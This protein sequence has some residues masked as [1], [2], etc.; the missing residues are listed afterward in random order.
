[1]DP[2]GKISG[3]TSTDAFSFKIVT[4]VSKWDY[5]T[6]EHPDVGSVL[7]QVIEIIRST[8]EAVAKCMIIGYRTERGFLRKP[9]TPFAPGSEVFH[10]SDEAIKHTLGLVTAGLY[11]GLLEGKEN[12]KTFID[13]RK[14][15]TKHLAILAKSGAGKSYTVGVILEELTAFGVP[16][17]VLDPHGE[18][19]S[20]RHANSHPDDSKYFKNYDIQPQGFGAQVQEYALNTA[21]NTSARQIKLKIPN[22]P[23]KLGEIMPFKLS[24]AQKGLLYNIVNDLVD[25]KGRFDFND[26]I[27]GLEMNESVAKWRLISGLRN[28]EKTN[29]F[30]FSP[31]PMGELV[32]PQQISIINFK[33][34]P[35]E[36]QEIAVSALVSELFEERKL[37]NISPFFLI[38]EEAHNYCP[39]RGFGEA[40]SSKVLRTVASEGR[41]FGLG[42]SIISQ[43]PGRVDKN[44]LSQCTS[45]ISLQVTNPNDLKAISRSFEG[46]TAE[47]EREIKNLPVGK[48]LVIGAA[49]YPIFVDIRVRKSQHGGRAKTFDMIKQEPVSQTIS[50]EIST[51]TVTAVS[52][53]KNMIYMFMPR[54]TQKDIEA[55][56][57]RNLKSAVM[58]L[59]PCLSVN[60]AFGSRNVHLVFDLQEMK[61][62]MLTDKLKAIRIPSSLSALSPMQRK[63]LAAAGSGSSMS[64]VFM[65]SGLGFSEVES[66]VSRLAQA[67]L[68]QVSGKQVRASGITNTANLAKLHFMDKAQYLETPRVEL[69]DIKLAE[70]QI[71]GFLSAS[72]IKAIGKRVSYLPFWKVQTNSGSKIVDGYGYS[73]NLS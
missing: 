54:I 61:I 37:E 26:I 51:P 7:G 58:V 41:K 72:G 18:Y 73:L 20:M 14:L 52:Q 27:E 36:L 4:K 50:S 48:A 8:E 1:M 19:S 29:L 23:Y 16:V 44:V 24:N 2:I 71:L 9:R 40:K 55:L 12:L 21:L 63:V 59:Q 10:A 32:R 65:K 60:C 34:A 30:S 56:E 69:R 42:I 35:I 31:T 43:R 25:K 28:L 22:S 15:I 46:V 13:P 3:R 45:Q 39:E 68:L 11:I 62:Y 49:D 53:P 67:G 66:V 70:N 38:I 57:A 5:I 6:I 47:T 33:G 64:E 17:V